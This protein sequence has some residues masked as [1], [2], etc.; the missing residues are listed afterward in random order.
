MYIFVSYVQ[1]SYKPLGKMQIKNNGVYGQ[2]IP[3]PLR[4]VD[5]CIRMLLVEATTTKSNSEWLK[6]QQKGGR[7]Y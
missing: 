1:L 4:P 5:V 6:Q 2:L 7:I 3:L